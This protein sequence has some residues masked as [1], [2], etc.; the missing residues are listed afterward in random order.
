VS[1][2]V[3]HALVNLAVAKYLAGSVGRPI[4]GAIASLSKQI[5]RAIHSANNRSMLQQ[6]MQARR[7]S[8]SDR[9]KS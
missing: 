3:S 9:A 5:A 1:H 6:R 2:G 8:V 7:K 4:I